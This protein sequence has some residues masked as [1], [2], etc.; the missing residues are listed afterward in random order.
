LPAVSVTEWRAAREALRAARDGDA[1]TV[2]EWRTDAREDNA[3]RHKAL[4]KQLA[5]MS[6]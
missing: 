1:L 5:V 4:W 2:V 6:S 3:R